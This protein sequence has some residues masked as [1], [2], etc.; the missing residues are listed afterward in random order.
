V[1]KVRVASCISLPLILEVSSFL[2]LLIYYFLTLHVW[3]ELR[4]TCHIT[5]CLLVLG[6]AAGGL[7]EQSIKLNYEVSMTS[8]SQYLVCSALGCTIL[9]S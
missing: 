6:Y 8:Q 1:V 5:A 9:A 4:I 7:W 2:L 3:C